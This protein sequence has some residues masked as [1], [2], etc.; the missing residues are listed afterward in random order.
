MS[1]DDFS[2]D[3]KTVDAIIR[4]LE[5]IGEAAKHIPVEMRETYPSIPWKEMSG[6]RDKL[7]HDYFGVDLK[8]VWKTIHDQLPELKSQINNILEKLDQ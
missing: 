7:I 8:V 2:G 5:I 4:N 6:M 1:F 3:L